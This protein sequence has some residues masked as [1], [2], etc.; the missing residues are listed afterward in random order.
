M[1]S[2][3]KNFPESLLLLNI[4]RFSFSFGV[5]LGVRIAMVAS[6]SFLL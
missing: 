2:F 3:E 6:F 4:L 5:G 1:V